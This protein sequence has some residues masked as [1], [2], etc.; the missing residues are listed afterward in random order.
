MRSNR[1]QVENAV[2]A[3]DVVS[4]ESRFSNV[5]NCSLTLHSTHLHI[6]PE[7]PLVRLLTR[8]L[9]TRL[10]Q[11]MIFRDIRCVTGIYGYH[12]NR[13]HPF[14]KITLAIP[15]LLAAAKRLLE[16]GFAFSSHP[17]QEYQ[18]YESNTEF[19]IRWEWVCTNMLL[20]LWLCSLC[21]MAYTLCVHMFVCV[22]VYRFEMQVGICMYGGCTCMYCTYHLYCAYLQMLDKINSCTHKNMYIFR[23]ES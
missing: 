23:S 10:D 22:C 7:F 8:T 3:V 17:L 9:Y 20:Q 12:G 14:L 16:Q 13:K 21:N 19:E 18:S 2:L 15:R 5:S 4:K 1:E 6:L 11:C